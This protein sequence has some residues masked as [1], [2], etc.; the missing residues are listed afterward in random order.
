V[1]CGREWEREAGRWQGADR[2]AWAAQCQAAWLK[3]I[4]TFQIQFKRAQTDSIQTGPSGN[5]EIK[6]GWKVFEM[7][8][9]FVY[10]NFVRFKIWRDNYLQC[11]SYLN[12]SMFRTWTNGIGRKL[13]R[14]LL[15]VVLAFC[16]AIFF[17][18][19]GIKFRPL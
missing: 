7:R 1:G 18:E 11:I 19:K 6:Y 3:W 15:V 13:K 8:N 16:K 2:R 5:F 17:L 12:V 9:N 4:Q 14:Q 10:R